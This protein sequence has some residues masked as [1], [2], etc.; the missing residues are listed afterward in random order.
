MSWTHCNC[1]EYDMRYSSK[2]FGQH[3][4]QYLFQQE[5][6]NFFVGIE[7]PKD[8]GSHRGGVFTDPPANIEQL[9][10]RMRDYIRN[11]VH[12]LRYMSTWLC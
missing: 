9:K 3:W 11:I 12:P 7:L 8:C 2:F 6:K 4:L 1:T 10:Q 5:L